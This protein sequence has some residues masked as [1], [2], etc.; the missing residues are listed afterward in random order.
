MS[1]IVGIV[2]G[3]ASE[4]VGLGLGVAG[5]VGIGCVVHKHVVRKRDAPLIGNLVSRTAGYQVDAICHVVNV[6]DVVGEEQGDVTVEGDTEDSALVH[7]VNADEVSRGPATRRSARRKKIVHCSDAGKP[8][9]ETYYGS[10][11]AD[12]RTLYSARGYS[13]YNAQL[14]RS[15]MV[16]TM[17]AHGVRPAHIMDR[18][19][20]MV[21][22]VFVVTEAEERAE[23]ERAAALRS[24]VMRSAVSG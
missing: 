15:Y 24:G 12:A 23:K 17:R 18:L 5:L 10:V 11:V 7:D 19:E 14:A 21:N 3:K 16:R 4:V 13:V 22:S 2:L 6:R 20:D 1:F 9:E 8:L